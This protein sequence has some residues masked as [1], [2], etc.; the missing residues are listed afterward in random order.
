[1]NSF[2]I[3]VSDVN[4]KVAL[5]VPELAGV[6]TNVVDPQPHRTGTASSVNENAGNLM[7]TVS[8]MPSATLR[9]NI[10]RRPVSA[11]VT[12]LK[13]SKTEFTNAVSITADD[14]AIICETMFVA[15]AM[16]ALAVLVF[17]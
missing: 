3:A 4:V 9:T 14:E 13:T 5:D 7:L 8:P 10:N 2:R 15:L 1:L 12:G 16:D 11:S 6:T 17:R